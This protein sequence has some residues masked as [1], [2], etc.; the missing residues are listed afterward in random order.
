M[1][2]TAA[3]NF[4]RGGGGLARFI[5]L[6]GNFEDVWRRRLKAGLDRFELVNLAARAV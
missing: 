5:G 3:T 2:K 6:L 1:E 4:T